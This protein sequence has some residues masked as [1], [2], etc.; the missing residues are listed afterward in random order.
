MYHLTCD[1]GCE[2]AAFENE[3][4]ETFRPMAGNELYFFRCPNCGW[5]VMVK[6]DCCLTD[7][8]ANEIIKLYGGREIDNDRTE[9]DA[10]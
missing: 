10:M 7:S 5:R 4:S 3:V 8:E 6:S 1:C 2:F 9:D